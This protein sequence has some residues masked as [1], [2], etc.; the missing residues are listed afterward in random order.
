MADFACEFRQA[1]A[2]EM[3]ADRPADKFLKR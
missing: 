3:T 2:A 1:L